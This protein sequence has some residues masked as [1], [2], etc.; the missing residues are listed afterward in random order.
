MTDSSYIQ[1]EDIYH[2]EADVENSEDYVPG[3]YHPTLIGDTLCSGRYT[4]VH[5]LGFGGYSTIWLARDNQ[6]QRY[7]SLKILTARASPDNHF[8]MKSDLAHSGKRFTPS[9]LGQFSFHGP[10]GHHRCLVGEPAG[11]NVA[12]PKE[13]SPNPCFRRTLLDLLPPSSS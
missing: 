9:L 12:N 13:D 4:V 2:P 7:V 11:A 1:V 8:P 3:G 6:R 5:K 10:N